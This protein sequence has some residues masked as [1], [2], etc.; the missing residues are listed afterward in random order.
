MA[1]DGHTK[2]NIDRAGFL[3]VMN[4]EQSYAQATQTYGPV[5]ESLPPE[6]LAPEHRGVY[7]T[8][9][10]NVISVLGRQ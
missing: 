2:G 5:G 9:H 7:P 10:G 4:G 8:D 3:K 6:R 1:A